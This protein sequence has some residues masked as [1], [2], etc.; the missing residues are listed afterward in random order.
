MTQ[1]RLLTR[2]RSGIF[3]SILLG[4]NLLLSSCFQLRPTRSGWADKMYQTRESLG[5]TLADFTQSID[6]FFGEERIEEEYSEMRLDVK[7][8]IFMEEH[9]TPHAALPVNGIFPL[10][11]LK[12]KIALVVGGTREVDDLNTDSLTK[13]DR[14]DVSSGLRLLSGKGPLTYKLNIGALWDDGVKIYVLPGVRYEQSWYDHI[15]R[16]TQTFRWDN[17]NNVGAYADLE[18]DKILSK[19]MVF[20]SGTSA[21]YA[22]DSDGVEF[23]QG[24]NFR[25]KARR[26]WAASLEYVGAMSTYPAVI[27]TSS[28]ITV[29]FRSTFLFPWLQHEIAPFLAFRRSNDFDRALGINYSL[30]FWFEAPPNRK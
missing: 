12:D 21:T 27:H 10:P 24:F 22:E 4:L 28:V 3:I 6:E 7:L 15:L 29:R 20:R 2:I 17:D 13:S 14:E 25:Y 26:F 1:G 5:S 8:K 19:F 23:S 9:K 18:Y 11:I 30:K 16:I